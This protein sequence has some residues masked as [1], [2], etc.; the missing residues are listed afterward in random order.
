[1]DLFGTVWIHAPYESPPTRAGSTRAQ[2]RTIPRPT[3]RTPPPA[4]LHPNRS[5]A[6]RARENV[7][8]RHADILGATPEQSARHP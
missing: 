1:M 8:H 6:R 7:Y 4:P 5:V 3:A 2:P